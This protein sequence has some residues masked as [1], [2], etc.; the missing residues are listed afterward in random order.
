MSFQKYFPSVVWLFRTFT[1]RLARRIYFATFLILLL[2][3]CMTLVPR[4]RNMLRARKFQ[5]VLAGLAKVKVDQ[6]TEAELVRLVPYL[7]RRYW[8]KDR[9]GR[10]VT[11]YGVEFSNEFDRS[12]S[13]PYRLGLDNLG[14]DRQIRKAARL[15]GVSFLSFRAGVL[16]RDGKVSRVSYAINNDG[17]WPRELGDMISVQSVHG[18]WL[19]KRRGFWVSSVVDESPQFR[20]WSG[21]NFGA[22]VPDG[23]AMGVTW[24]FDA[25][26]AL[27][28]HAYQV[29]LSCAWSLHG[30]LSAHDMAPLLWQ[31]EEKIKAATRERLISSEPCP[32]RIL[33]GR[34]RYLPDMDILLLEVVDF[35]QEDI[36]EEGEQSQDFNTVYK[37]IEV[38]RGRT[39]YPNKLR[40]RY[41]E[42]T[43]SPLEGNGMGGM[44]LLNPLNP[45]HKAG[46]Q[47]LFFT[48]HTFE[49]CQVVPATPSALSVVRTT[50]PAPK[51]SG[52]QIL[53]GLQ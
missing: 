45:H 36:N 51:F 21:Q 35:Q 32:D 46:D 1:D 39:N 17:G 3:P 28:S 7:T 6:T 18:P 4:L 11:R 9:D 2:L 50:V 33:A 14:D 20:V 42:L 16:V 25:P 40:L 47:V 30:C 8:G 15:L 52:D 31:D 29:D 22:R 53:E 44:A 5:A 48:N 49:T 34:V 10:D 38:I 26:P 23:N 12:T 41:R 37:V 27:I 43:L 24:T 13:W 19:P